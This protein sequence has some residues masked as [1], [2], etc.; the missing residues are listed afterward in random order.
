M[1]FSCSKHLSIW[2]KEVLWAICLMET[3]EFICSA[4]QLIDFPKKGLP[5]KL[6]IH[7]EN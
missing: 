6:C 2:D 7:T 5:I 1:Q 4:N 3:S